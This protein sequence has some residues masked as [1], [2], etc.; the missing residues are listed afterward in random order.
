[1]NKEFLYYYDNY[2]F[3]LDNNYSACNYFKTGTLLNRCCTSTV[4]FSSIPSIMCSLNSLNIL[5]L[6][7]QGINKNL[8][9]IENM[10]NNQGN[11]I[12]MC[13]QWLRPCDMFTVRCT[14]R[15][16]SKWTNLKSGMDDDDGNGTGRPY[17]GVGFITRKL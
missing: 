6:N 15:Q 13:E 7:C 2:K 10:L 12:Y 11:I 9:Y 14:Y 16:H 3:T 8:Q 1:M 4:F 5:S 17:G